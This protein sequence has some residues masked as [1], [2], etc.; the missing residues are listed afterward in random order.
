M[1]RVA[2]FAAKQSDL[3]EFIEV[4]STDTLGCNS[5]LMT[6]KTNEVCS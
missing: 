4:L 6:H 1:A 3:F 2:S 5:V